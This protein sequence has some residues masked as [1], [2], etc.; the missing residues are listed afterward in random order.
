LSIRALR[1]EGENGPARRHGHRRPASS[2]G[3]LG[4]NVNPVGELG[5]GETEAQPLLV[6]NPVAPAK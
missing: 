5:S 6:R 3:Q 2:A 4:A 1:V